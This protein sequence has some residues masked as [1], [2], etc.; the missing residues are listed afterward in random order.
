MDNLMPFYYNENNK[1]ISQMER[2]NRE[3]AVDEL[4]TAR[5]SD[6]EFNEFLNDVGS[7]HK[8]LSKIIKEYNRTSNVENKKKRLKVML[9][10]LREIENKYPA[11]LL[12]DSSIY[13]NIKAHIFKEVKAQ[14]AA[15]EINSITG[16]NAAD[17]ASIAEIITNMSP[18]KA[19]EL[20][21]ILQRHQVCNRVSLSSLYDQSDTS[22][23]A[24]NWCNFLNNHQI[25]FL[26]G[27]NSKNYKVVNNDSGRIEV[28]KVDDNSNPNSIQNKLQSIKHLKEVYINITSERQTYHLPNLGQSLKVT[29]FFPCGDLQ[30]AVTKP[31]DMEKR[32]SNT[33][34]VFSQ[35]TDVMKILIDNQL[36][37]PDSKNANWLLDSEGNLKIADTKSFLY[38]DENGQYDR[39]SESNK[40]CG[41]PFV[42]PGLEIDEIYDN[43]PY[44]ADKLHAYILAK[45][46]YQG[47]TGCDMDTLLRIDNSDIDRNDI[48]QGNTGFK[49]NHAIFQSPEGKIYQS[50]I[51]KLHSHDMSVKDA[52][53]VFDFIKL[54]RQARLVIHDTTFTNQIDDWQENYISM[55]YSEKIKVISVILE[56]LKDE[57]N[58]D[59]QI[60]HTIDYINQYK[61]FGDPA[62]IDEQ[63]QIITQ[64]LNHQSTEVK[65]I[66]VSGLTQLAHDLKKADQ[67]CNLRFDAA[68]EKIKKH[69]S[70]GKNDRMLESF[71]EEKRQ[72][73]NN[74][75][76]PNNKKTIITELE[77]LSEKLQNQILIEALQD[78]VQNLESKKGL[79]AIG[80]KEKV[81]HISQATTIEER[82]SL[83]EHPAKL[84]HI[85][86][87]LAEHRLLGL[88]GI[89]YKNGNGE[90]N[91][92]KAAKSLDYFKKAI[93]RV[94]DKH[95]NNANT[96]RH[97]QPEVIVSRRIP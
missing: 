69:G 73:Y 91:E 63:I 95:Y 16:E 97:E 76:N 2:F 59:H 84:A 39:N 96:P 50:M 86:E 44:A 68:L 71:L 77:K 53:P 12:T 38:L 49:F 70:I 25:S 93:K 83:D 94:K 27:G 78:T 92:E 36:F 5:Y 60:S 18:D 7:V 35:M 11:Y 14:Y 48:E 4:M 43:K 30:S 26:G 10:L 20:T 52:Q 21:G 56:K 72:N 42:T 3:M 66:T 1:T 46:L 28:L 41:K 74:Q 87:A 45:N 9:H 6:D 89:V 79:F 54:C 88:R 58:L 82:A 57:E 64:N 13:R 65:K 51:E 67:D 80:V 47:L 29:E 15:F 32:L 31:M 55:A 90:I 22:Q 81:T 85:E 24:K 19:D 40:Y 75:K 37:F 61:S 62:V 17:P 34:N 8:Q 33:L 23:E